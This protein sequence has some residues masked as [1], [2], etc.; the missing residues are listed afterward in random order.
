VGIIPEKMHTEFETRFLEI[1]KPALIEK[2]R[3]LGADDMGET[4]LLEFIFYDKKLSW[5]KNDQ[6]IRLRKS[7][8]K[9]FLTYKNN[10]K[11]SV[12]SAQEIEFVVSDMEKAKIFL[13]QIGFVNYRKIE[14]YRHT[15]VMDGVT[16]DIDM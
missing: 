5:L 3:S 2:L 12:D 15:F 7:A 6:L 16:F 11:Q 13:E 8:D 4:R 10:H 9:V 14:K 1:K